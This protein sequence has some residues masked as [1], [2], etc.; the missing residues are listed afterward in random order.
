MGHAQYKKRTL[1]RSPGTDYPVGGS[2]KQPIAISI[3]LQL[4]A[5]N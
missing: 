4:F 1:I 5:E 3:V 2:K